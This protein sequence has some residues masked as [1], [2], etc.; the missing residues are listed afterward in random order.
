[1]AQKYDPNQEIVQ[2]RAQWLK[3]ENCQKQWQQNWGWLIEETLKTQQEVAAIRQAHYAAAPHRPRQQRIEGNL[4]PVPVTSAGV[5]GWL[6]TRPDC[7]LE[8]Y[9]PWRTKIPLR[10]PEAWE[11]ESYFTE[12]EKENEKLNTET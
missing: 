10:A 1:M 9:T 8:I 7:K 2:S 4:R 3:A 11:S 5:I 12:K 6:S